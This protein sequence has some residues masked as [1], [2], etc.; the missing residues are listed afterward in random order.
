MKW[1][2]K[3]FVVDKKLLSVADELEGKNDYT[4]PTA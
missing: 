4:Q 1:D 2:G 3:K